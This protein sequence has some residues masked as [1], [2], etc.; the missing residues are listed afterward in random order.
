MRVFLDPE[1]GYVFDPAP[2]T[3]AEIRSKSVYK[4]NINR[5]V[6]E[7]LPGGLFLL[8]DPVTAEKTESMVARIAKAANRLGFDLVVGQ[9]ISEEIEDKRELVAEKSRAGIE[10]KAHDAKYADR[11][12]QYAEVVNGAFVRPLRQRQMWDSF[13]MCAMGKAGNFSVP[14]SGKTASVLGVFAYLEAKGLVSRIVVICPKNAFESWRNEFRACFGSDKELTEF[15]VQAAAFKVLPREE[16]KRRLRVDSGGCNLVLVNYD[17]MTAYEEELKQLVAGSTLLVFDEVHRVKRIKGKQASSALEISSVCDRTIALTGTP[18]PNTYQDIYNFLNILFPREYGTFF[19]FTPNK[20]KNP[21]EY[22]VAE[23]NAKI[24]PF[25]CRTT[26]DDLGVP[27]INPDVVTHVYADSETERLLDVLKMKYKKNLLAL[28]LRIM[29]LESNPRLLLEDLNPAEY[30]WLLHEDEETGEIDYVDYS[31][32]IES[33]IRNAP[34]SQKV[35]ECLSLVQQLHDQGKPA[36]VWCVLVG[37]M[38]AL[39]DALRAKGMR[40]ALIYGDV[41]QEE[42]ESMLDAF[43]AGQIDVLVTNPHTLAESVSLHS[44]C[45]DAVYFEYSFNLVHLLQSKDRIHRLGLPEGQYTQYYFLQNVYDNY[46]DGYS[47]DERVYNRL[48][49]KEQTMLTAIADQKLETLPTTDEDLGAI[50]KGLFDE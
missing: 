37:T 38:H 13:F 47:M 5:F 10:I 26:K 27:A 23:I 25:F 14:G 1:R 46:N 32:E 40:V 44:V 18:I 7:E 4:V 24:Q 33:M 36:I 31:E 16:R 45:H 6:E 49:E 41:S 39:T 50:F 3:A 21:S 29:Q 15:N 2:L 20:L 22:E 43:R 12:S 17:A 19:N 8:K 35:G 48:L 42:R 34:A 30:S 11:F 28:M 9:E